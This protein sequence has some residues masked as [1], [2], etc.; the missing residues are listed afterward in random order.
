MRELDEHTPVLVEE[1]LAAL[2]LRP[3]GLYVDATFGRGGHS[4]RILQALGPEGRVLAHRSRSGGHRGRPAAL[5]ARTAAAPRARGVRRARRAA[6]ARTGSAPQCDGILFDLGVSSP[7]LDDPRAA[8]ASRRRPARY[9]HGPDARR[10]GLRVARSGEQRRDSPGDRHAWARSA[11][12][13]AWPQAIVRARATQPLTRTGAAGGAG[14]ARGAHARAG[15]ASGDA[16]L[17]GAAHAHQRRARTARARPG[18]GAASCSR[19]G[20][21]LAAISF[22]SLEDRAGQALHRRAFRA[23]SGARAPAA[24]PPQ[25]AAAAAPHR[26]QAARRARRKSR[27]TRAPAA[28][29]CAWRESDCRYEPRRATSC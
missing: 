11:L 5:C 7:Q 4:A 27:A 8:S 18:A 21:R 6:C 14:G 20:G 9:A 23:R 28:R 17:P 1:V 12:P 26:P 24:L 22:H 16:H 19:R 25:R 13:A 2:A 29:C 3:G 15:Q 10:A